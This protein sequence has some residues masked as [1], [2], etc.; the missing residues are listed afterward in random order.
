ME[1]NSVAKRPAWS[2]RDDRVICEEFDFEWNGGF[3]ITQKQKNIANLHAAIKKATNESALEISSKGLVA[4]G[5][6]MGAFS[7]KYN[8]I[9][10]ENV[11]QSSKKYEFGGPYADLLNVSPKEAK[12]DERHKNSGSIVAFCL[13]GKE[14]P[15]IP[16][17]L[18]YDYIYIKA[19][20]QNFGTGLDLTKYDW[21]TD[22]EFN[23]KK[24]I[25][26]Q[27]RSAA[28]YK[29]LQMKNMFQILDDE[30]GWT[31]FHSKCVL[32]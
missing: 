23:P 30:N 22:I 18:F 1:G 20:I 15:L 7:L 32:G 28:I 25:N 14:W 2:I 21:F 26:C 3:Y 24:S 12:Q 19:A 16:N 17:T 6:S 13:D 4:L 27:A 5:N 8:G 9:P 31:E 10:L 11:F 29:L